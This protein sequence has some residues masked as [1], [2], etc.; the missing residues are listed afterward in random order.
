M[1]EFDRF[2]AAYEHPMP[3][4][5]DLPTPS[6][7]GN[8]PRF[9]AVA[10]PVQ[11]VAGTL[12]AF[13]PKDRAKK[14]VRTKYASAAATAEPLALDPDMVARLLAY[15]VERE[16]I[17]VKKEAGEPWP[18]TMD[19]ILQAGSFCN[20]RRDDDRGSR[21]IMAHI[22]GPNR[23]DPELWHKLTIARCINE[24]DALAELA[25]SA[26]FDPQAIR[27]TLD[28]RQARGEVVYRTKAY[29][30]PLPPVALKGMRIT[31]YL[32]DYVLGPLWHDREEL[33]PQDGDTLEAAADRLIGREGLGPFR[34]GQII[35]DLK[36]APPLQHAADWRTFVV[37]GPGSL[38]GLNR[39]CK[40]NVK[41]SWS[42][43]QWRATLLH[44]RSTMAPQ[45]EA[46]GLGW[47]DAQDTQ[48]H[49]CE[50]DKY[51]RAIENDGLPSR[52]YRAAAAAPKAKAKRAKLASTKESSEV[53]PEP[54]ATAAEPETETE[55]HKAD[56]RPQT[57]GPRC[58]DAALDYAI[59]FGWK[60]FPAVPGTKKS[61]KSAQ[62]SSGERWG[63]TRDPEQIRR[64]FTRWPD[65]MIGI[66]T[67]PDNGFWV[68]EI[69]TTKG[70][71]A[72]DGFAALAALIAQHGPL[73]ETLTAES[74]SGSR[75][76]YFRWPQGVEI[77][78]R[79]NWPAPGIDIRGDG[80]MVIAPP[81]VRADGAYR[82]I[83]PA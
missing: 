42:E 19:P 49:L 6:K 46:A 5:P 47:F 38:R 14:A 24:P 75:H 59:R 26:P 44:L 36:H 58:L 80:G 64:D 29:K 81:S 45:L 10:A 53:A 39:V 17:R 41:A 22:I 8:G 18:W 11:H 66:P 37:P 31:E 79:A 69:D 55:Q 70:G 23:D 1:S 21:W 63:A 33:R 4:A 27:A 50:F 78:N 34:V 28:A 60:V 35:A 56:P 82:W 62:Y 9:A 74:P 3:E 13:V 2:K 12:E 77:R 72:N 52:K 76:Y 67:G 51:M 32:I 20:V 16:A 48:N 54:R 83:D 25:W 30:P 15:L 73:P 65:A 40:R 7:G 68:L 71:H 61:Y 57:P 43:A